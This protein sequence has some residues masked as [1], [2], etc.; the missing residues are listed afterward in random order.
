MMT[1]NLEDLSAKVATDNKFKSKNKMSTLAEKMMVNVIMGKI[2]RDCKKNCPE[3]GKILYV[4]YIFSHNE[5]KEIGKEVYQWSKHKIDA[6]MTPE[7]LKRVKRI[8]PFKTDKL[9]EGIFE[10]DF[11]TN[12]ITGTFKNVGESITRKC[13]WNG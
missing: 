2:R 8:V 6:L 5:G 7:D 10:L 4:T 3:F 12:I 13:E 11:T 1:L 9:D